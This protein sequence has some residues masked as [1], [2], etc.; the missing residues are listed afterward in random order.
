MGLKMGMLDK[1]TLCFQQDLN[2]QRRAWLLLVA[3]WRESLTE[4]REA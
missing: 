4:K 2:L 3:T 1:T